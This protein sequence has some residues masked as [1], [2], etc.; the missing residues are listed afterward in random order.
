MPEMMSALSIFL[1]E[2]QFWIF[3]FSN[4]IEVYFLKNTLEK[5]ELP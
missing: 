4:E 2:F 3:F 5:L 1:I